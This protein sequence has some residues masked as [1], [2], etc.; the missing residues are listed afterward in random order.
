MRAALEGVRSYQYG[1]DY[2]VEE[3][4]FLGISLIAIV[5]SLAIQLVFTSFGG[6]IAAYLFII[7]ALSRSIKFSR[8]DVIE[9]YVSPVS[10]AS[11]E[12]Y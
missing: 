2:D 4:Q 6:E 12:K 7:M 3:Y 10:S 8:E 1:F 9:G 11:T 5:Y